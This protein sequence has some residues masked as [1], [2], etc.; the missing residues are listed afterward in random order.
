[1]CS[2]EM[3]IATQVSFLECKPR[4]Y[5]MPASARHAG[6]ILNSVQLEK[7]TLEITFLTLLTL[8]LG[9]IVLF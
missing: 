4:N 3:N 6:E 9:K 1:M 7:L 2:L 8:F 5:Y